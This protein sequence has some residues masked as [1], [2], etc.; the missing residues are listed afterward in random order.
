MSDTA[1]I[2]IFITGACAGLA[3][4]RQG[5][6]GHPEVEIAGTAVDPDKAHEKLAAAGA[7]VILHG[8]ARADRLPA[9]EIDALRQAT[10]APIVL[11]TSG[12]ASGLLTAALEAGIHDVI[13]L[14]QLTDALVFSIR[15]TAQLA[16]TRA[17]PLAPVRASAADGKVVTVFSPKGGVG[18][19]VLACAL[20]AQVA[21]QEGRRV[22]LIDL[23]LQFGDAAIML[24]IE[25]EKT[26]YDLVMTTGELDP[27]KLAGYVLP[28]PSG[29]D[30][31]PA[32]VRPED[33][34]LVSE[35]RVG[36]LLD[37]AKEAY[38][39]VVVDTPAFFQATTLATLDRTDQL[40]LVSS[41]DIP[42]IKNVKLA[43][44]TLNLLH[45]PRERVNLVLNQ[46]GSRGDLKRSEVEK[47]LD[48]KVAFTIPADK[49]VRGAV[50]RGL[51]VPLAAPRAAMTKMV[52]EIATAL[53]T[54]AAAGDGARTKARGRRRG[55]NHTG[56]A[57]KAA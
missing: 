9:G 34:E 7:H 44:Q 28:H 38:D 26:V 29:I 16:T 24:G 6:A 31:V 46:C 56:L 39:L 45:Y 52:G 47:A 4:V 37:V 12:N 8:C 21:R 17:V 42:S 3:E 2:R 23:D 13:M 27:E 30:V 22:L 19:T 41:L 51:P 33:A 57:R 14:P 40:L 32:P 35:E 53:V 50:N 49:E 25:P 5:L 20:A 10:T 48:L 1:P 43:L 36:R 11:V 54:P 15:K 55:R 18:K